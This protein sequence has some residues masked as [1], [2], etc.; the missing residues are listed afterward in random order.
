M[1]FVQFLK[2]YFKYTQNLEVVY[3]LTEDNVQVF[4]FPSLWRYF[5]DIIM[6]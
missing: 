6:Y 4:G 5:P 1:L 3:L 2:N